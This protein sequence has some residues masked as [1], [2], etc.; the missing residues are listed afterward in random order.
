MARKTQ[1]PALI[2]L[3]F[4]YPKSQLSLL[5]HLNFCMRASQLASFK[6]LI[7]S[8]TLFVH[9]WGTSG[10]LFGHFWGTS[11]TLFVHLW[12]TSVPPTNTH[13]RG[14]KITIFAAV[15][16]ITTDGL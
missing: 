4:F 14:P 9:F 5:I 10:T 1:L 16:Q 11:G 8:G 6:K 2:R 12:G 13:R 3:I 7:T 15:A